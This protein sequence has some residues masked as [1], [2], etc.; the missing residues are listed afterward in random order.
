[1]LVRLD[2]FRE[3]DRLTRTLAQES[4]VGFAPTDAYK[5]GDNYVIEMDL[6]GVDPEHI[7]VTVE[8]NVLSVSATRESV[9]ED[10]KADALV[11]ERFSGTFRRSMYLGNQLDTSNIQA[12]YDKGVLKLTIPVSASAKSRKI[13]IS[14]GESKAQKVLAS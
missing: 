12:S 1:M 13:E 11:T 3:I 5:D 6:P 2:P 14:S 9:K 10:R 4:S 7:E 8:N